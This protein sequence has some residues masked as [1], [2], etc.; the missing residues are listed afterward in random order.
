MCTDFCVQGSIRPIRTNGCWSPDSNGGGSA[1][2]SNSPGCRYIAQN[3]DYVMK[4][5]KNAWIS[6]F[7][8]DFTDY[9]SVVISFWYTGYSLGNGNSCQAPSS[10]TVLLQISTNQ[11]QSLSTLSSETVTS[12]W[13]ELNY[14]LPGA[15]LTSGV[16]LRIYTD[17]G[18]DKKYVL[19]DSTSIDLNCN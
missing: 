7:D 19:L 11:G 12:S 17:G 8:Y 3:G 1:S 16:R 4:L 13:D 15:Y 9:A 10:Q 18:N 14:T 5:Y 6:T 2:I